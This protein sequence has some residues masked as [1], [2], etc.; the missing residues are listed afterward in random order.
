M[1]G[2]AAVQGQPTAPGIRIAIDISVGLP[3]G[4]IKGEGE[5]VACAPQLGNDST[6]SHGLS[7][8]LMACKDEMLA[9]KKAI[10]FEVLKRTIGS[11]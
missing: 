4:D 8:E 11:R 2:G 9:L 7:K 5:R 3:T 10:G 1:G 6:E